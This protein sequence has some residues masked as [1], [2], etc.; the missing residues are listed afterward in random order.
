MKCAM[1]SPSYPASSSF[2]QKK[3]QFFF[4]IIIIIA[5][6]TILIWQVPWFGYLRYKSFVYCSVCISI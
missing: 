6:S 5:I 3:F 2:K 4:I 1:N